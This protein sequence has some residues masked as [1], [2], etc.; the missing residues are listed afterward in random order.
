MK[1]YLY[2]EEA[3]LRSSFH[4]F[5]R[6]LFSSAK[7][8]KTMFSLFSIFLSSH[9]YVLHLTALPEPLSLSLS[10]SPSLH[11]SYLT[12]SPGRRRR[13]SPRWPDRPAPHPAPPPPPAPP[14]A[15]P[16]A[17]VANAPPPTPALSA[18]PP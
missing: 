17:S 2:S 9:L 14:A 10:L 7:K 11:L 1:I 4:F 16:V 8:R 12:A 13:C 3:S 6:L 15:D 18:E 5:K